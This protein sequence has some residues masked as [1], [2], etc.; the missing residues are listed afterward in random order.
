MKTSTDELLEIA[1]NLSDQLEALTETEE[2]IEDEMTETEYTE[3]LDALKKNTPEFTTLKLIEE[4]AELQEKLI[5]Y[6]LKSPSHKPKI[7]EVLDEVGDVGLRITLF[8]EQ[9]TTDEFDATE[10]VEER[11]EKKVKKLYGYHKEGKYKG[12]L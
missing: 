7:Q 10:Y 12:G 2:T 5:K 1:Q 11:V 6:H 3:L 9:H 8:L 4:L